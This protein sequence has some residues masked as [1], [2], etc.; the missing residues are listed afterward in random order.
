MTFKLNAW[1]KSLLTINLVAVLP[2]VQDRIR[3][4]YC[5]SFLGQGC[6]WQTIQKISRDR[7]SGK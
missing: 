6:I 2:L 1:N 3:K 5:S 4:Q 7:V